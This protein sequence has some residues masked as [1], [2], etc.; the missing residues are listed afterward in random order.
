MSNPPP[1][2]CGV[3][4]LYGMPLIGIHF[5]FL[6]KRVIPK[7]KSNIFQICSLISLTLLQP[8][9]QIGQFSSVNL[10]RYRAPFFK[11]NPSQLKLTCQP[12]TM[13]TKAIHLNSSKSCSFPPSAS[14]SSQ[15]Q[16]YFYLSCGLNLL[17]FLCVGENKEPPT[18]AYQ[19]DADGYVKLAI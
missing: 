5:E 7:T 10:S 3:D 12:E 6:L 2:S 14:G 13:N 15:S 16:I 18:P 11:N 4:V 9:A 8:Q 19:R 17:Q 1:S